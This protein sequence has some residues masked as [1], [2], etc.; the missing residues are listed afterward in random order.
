M[1]TLDAIKTRRA[2][3]SWAAKPVSDDLL[4]KILAA[5]HS[6]PSPLNSQPWHFT[7]I[8]KKETLESLTKHAQH[9]SFCSNADTLIVVTVTEQAAVDT[10]LAE[11]EQ[12]FFAG[13]CAAQNM[14][15]A[16]WDL[17]LGTCWVTLDEKTTRKLLEIPSNH[18]IIGSLALGYPSGPVKPHEEKD[19][20]PLVEK[21]SYEKFSG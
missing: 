3:R 1:Q 13:A 11:H 8:R 9:G 7:I 20:K 5:G 6:A 16:A 19:R 14:W 12:H 4:Q 10:W 18:K 17:G 15:L 2:V 21:I